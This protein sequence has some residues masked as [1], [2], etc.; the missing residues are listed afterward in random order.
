MSDFKNR[1]LSKI[2][3]QNDLSKRNGD[4]SCHK[5]KDGPLRPDLVCS[6]DREGNILCAGCRELIIP[7]DITGDEFSA[8]LYQFEST[9]GVSNCC[10]DCK[11]SWYCSKCCFVT[12][13][14]EGKSFSTCGSAMME[15]LLNPDHGS[16]RFSSERNE[17]YW[18]YLRRFFEKDM[19]YGHYQNPLKGKTVDIKKLIEIYEGPNADP[20]REIKEYKVDMKK[21]RV[22]KS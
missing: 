19:K 1:R 6:R 7:C 11:F 2:E 3:Y 9:G 22:N 15:Q 10:Y 12:I 13:F 5:K 20:K 8:I 16:G 17:K 18:L 14:E 21:Y 4:K